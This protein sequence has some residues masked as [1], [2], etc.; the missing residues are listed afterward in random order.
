MVILLEYMAASA[1]SY[2]LPLM[3]FG[4]ET[5]FLVERGIQ[6]SLK[7]QNWYQRPEIHGQATLTWL[8]EIPGEEIGETARHLAVANM[9]A[10]DWEKQKKTPG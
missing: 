8:M 6:L 9:E 5:G 3:G 10:Q 1:K 2:C 7:T 4:I